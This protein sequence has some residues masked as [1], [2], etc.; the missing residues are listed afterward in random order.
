MAD[1]CAK[2]EIDLRYPP[3]VLCT[4]NAAMIACAGYYRYMA[5]RRDGMSLNAIPNLKID[6]G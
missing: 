2:E 5:G 6:Q 1:L 4:D 3:L